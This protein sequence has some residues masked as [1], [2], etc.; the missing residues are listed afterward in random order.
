MRVSRRDNELNDW[1][2]LLDERYLDASRAAKADLEIIGRAWDSLHPDELEFVDQEISKCISDRRYFIE[3]YYT[4]RTEKGQLRTLYPLWDHQLLINEVIEEEWNKKGCVCLIILKPRQAG[5]TEFN[6][7]IIFHDTIFTPNAYTL[8]M[9]QRDD[10]SLEIFNRMMNAYANLPWWLRPERASKQQGTH[11]IFQ[12]ADE[13]RRILDPGLGST[14]IISSANKAAGI[15]IG[16]TIKNLLASEC[17]RW[18]DA[19]VWTADIRPSLNAPDML[20]IMESTAFGRSGLYHNMWKAAEKGR[21]RWRALFIPV[22]KVR[23]YFLPV[24]KSEGFTLTEDE[25]GLR[26]N[27][28]RKEEFKIPLGFFKWYRQ[29]VQECINSTGKDEEVQESY[30]LTADAAFIS[31]GFCAFPRKELARQEKIHVC[32]PILIGEIEYVGPD[33]QP[34]LHLH[35]PTPDEISEKPDRF[36]RFWVWELPEEA[37][38]YQI[39][40]DQGGSG[41]EN[42]FTDSPVYKIGMDT[43]DKNTSIPDVLVA[44]WHGHINASHMAKVLAAIGFWYN[45]AEIAVEYARDGIT[46]GNDLQWVVDY[47][48]IYR[49]RRLDKVG[50]TMSMHT[51][52]MTTNTTRDDMINRMNERLLDH[53]IEI[54]NKFAI[55]EMRDFGREENQT[56]AQGIDNN[57]DMAIGHMIAIASANQSNRRQLRAEAMAQGT[58]VSSAAAAHAMPKVPVVFNLIDQYGRTVQQVNSEQEGRKVIEECSKKVKLDLSKYWKILPVVV[59]KANTPFSPSW[60]SDGSE[61]ELREQYGI[62]PRN[63]DPGIVALYRHLLAN[64]KNSENIFDEIDEN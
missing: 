19:S 60:D 52:W 23:K 53:Q 46:T 56:K 18:P 38:D 22:Y 59:M 26:Q 61:R 50:N 55:E 47:P 21:S 10:V 12:R 15:A 37:G 49:W 33:Q 30:P 4:I 17:S 63:Q 45:T 36:N 51:H 62:E 54:R 6:G 41:E 64:G 25:R 3:N 9:A 35:K 44:E 48:S 40:C 24:Y 58:G 1:I 42:D 14:L 29:E 2:E 31:S 7:A 34:V 27:V 43:G 28:M 13:N 5:S 39:A 8:A 32:D 16:K 57:D 11:V 20:A